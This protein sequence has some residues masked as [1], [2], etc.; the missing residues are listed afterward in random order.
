MAAAR[1]ARSLAC[2]ALTTGLSA[3]CAELHLGAA[4]TGPSVVNEMSR[5]RPGAAP[6]PAMIL[7]S[8]K[9]GMFA[10]L[11]RAVRRSSPP[12]WRFGLEADRLDG[13]WRLDGDVDDGRGPGALLV[14]VTLRPGMLLAHPCA[15]PE[16]RQGAR[17]VE[18]PM[19]GGD[20]LVLRS[21]VVEAGDMRT[22]QAV[23]VHGDGSG[24]GAEAGNWT[25]GA[26][27][28][29]VSGANDLPVPQVTRPEPLYT[30]GEL[31]QLVEAVA[32]SARQC[33]RTNCERVP[34]EERVRG[35]TGA[36]EHPSLRKS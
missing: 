25:L 11:L 31:A 18:R 32:R 21:V 6:D 35:S 12:G 9:D 3:G 16:F 10:A 5:P 19:P 1:W 24:V 26:L 17:C 22:I 15:D 13:D 30:V 23:L 14:E 8:T 20:L 36:I 28:S 27:P 34:G 33:I 4:S 29:V 2:V 7:S